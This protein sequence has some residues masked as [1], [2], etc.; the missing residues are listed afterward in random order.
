VQN[1]VHIR[2]IL[3]AGTLAVVA[4]VLGF[5]TLSM[6]QTASK[7][8]V[9]KIVPLKDRPGYKARLVSSAAKPQATTKKVA[10]RKP[11]PYL[12]A[13]LRAGLPRSVAKALAARPVAVVVLG[14]PSDKVSNLTLG[15]AL[16]GAALAGASFVAVDVDADGGDVEQL[17][18]VLGE[19]PVTPATLV[20]A[21]PGTLYVT[22]AGF[23][24]RT[25]VQ[26]AVA[27][28]ALLRPT[29]P[30]AAPPAATAATSAATTPAATSAGAG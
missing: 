20:Y 26:Q 3:I 11:N 10:V 2:A 27:N 5:F 23:N 24:D 21:R 4:L 12:L 28:A 7:A 9:T 6:N 15:E 18:R 14:S 29:S 25:T 8:A 19:L 17:T 13:A 16:V 30:A 1:S 22:L